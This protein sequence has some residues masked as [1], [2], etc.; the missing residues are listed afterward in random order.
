MNVADLLLQNSGVNTGFPKFPSSFANLDNFADQYFPNFKRGELSSGLEVFVGAPNNTEPENV[1]LVKEYFE[2]VYYTDKNKND[3]YD[4]GDILLANIKL[5]ASTDGAFLRTQHK[6]LQGHLGEK[7]IAVFVELPSGDIYSG[8]FCAVIASELQAKNAAG[9][10][11]VDWSGITNN[12]FEL[13]D[14]QLKK[15]ITSLN[16]KP[17]F[18]DTVWLLTTNTILRP[19]LEIAELGASVFTGIA[20][21]FE[22]LRISP[23]VYDPDD[24][25]Y[26]HISVAELLKPYLNT[27]GDQV[28]KLIESVVGEVPV[29]VRNM[30][31][32]L[33]AL[34]NTVLSVLI[35]II[36]DISAFVVGL[37]CGVWNSLIDLIVGIFDLIA[38]VFKMVINITKTIIHGNYYWELLLEYADNFIQYIQKIDW[39]DVVESAVQG[40]LTLYKDISSIPGALFK[41]VTE[42]NFGEY[43]YYVGYILFEV[44]QLFLPILELA[45][46]GKLSKLGKLDDIIKG[47]DIFGD[48]KKVSKKGFDVTDFT[49]S[50]FQTTIEFVLEAF[51]YFIKKLKSGTAGFKKWID[52]IFGAIKRW[53]DDLLGFNK[54]SEEVTE[55][56]RR[57]KSTTAK[58]EVLFR[59]SELV[60]F[61]KNLENKYAHLKLKVNIVTP[62]S[63]ANRARLKR[64]DQSKVLGSF[65]SG[66]PPVIYVRQRCSHLTMQHEIWHLEDYARL[67]SVEYKKI[68]NWKH[69]E[70]VWMKVFKNKEQ[71]S[72]AELID[73]YKYYLKSAYEEGGTPILNEDL[74]TIIRKI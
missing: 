14:F 10:L 34:S 28:T 5:F 25:N 63:P 19:I 4:A 41:K 40:A 6:N 50:K 20:K 32:Q 24:K 49:G 17:D 9:F 46:L 7:D 16:S 72:E 1:A 74:D 55:L 66:P 68:P 23:S 15:L 11:K 52:D 45:K 33:Y 60:K 2:G 65:S 61:A 27:N 58:G 29:P 69:E 22:S 31:E 51:E 47:L 30:I 71:W 57:G 36:E 35:E 39:K 38:L 44:V 43:G 21:A 18:W 26:S 67:G 62:N 8:L 53:M 42:I 64:W 56:F 13:Q 73:S 3:F 59:R 54:T 12:A 48:A 70:S 37:V